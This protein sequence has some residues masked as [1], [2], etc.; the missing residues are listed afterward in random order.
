M[1]ITTKTQELATDALKALGFSGYEARVYLTL[2]QGGT[3]TGYE[4]AKASGIPR[5]NVY[6]VIEHLLQRG[7]I[8]PVDAA[9]TARYAAVPP[10]ELLRHLAA[11]QQRAVHTARSALRAFAA[12]P[13]PEAVYNLKGEALLTAARQLIDGCRRRLLVA[14]Q[15]T[16]A[17]A[18]ALPLRQARDRGVEITTLCLEACERECGG[19]QGDI[20]RLA[21]APAADGR[22]LLLVAD[23]AQTL[24]AERGDGHGQ[25]LLTRQPL[26]VELAASYILQSLTL[27]LIGSEL[28]SRFEGLLS[29]QTRQLLD[30]LYVSGGFL[31][32]VKSLNGAGAG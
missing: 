18:L 24:I 29:T 6:A 19:C 8:L 2:L 15:P 4:V 14:V 25:A 23:Q 17:A 5:A 9:A 3:L 20:R 30:R 16:E 31:T 13:V 32:Y 10:Q 27:A 7:V 1:Y 22:W 12:R 28:A 26:V 11:E 21:L